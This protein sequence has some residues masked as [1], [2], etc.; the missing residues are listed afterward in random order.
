MAI[1]AAE[2]ILRPCHIVCGEKNQILITYV[3]VQVTEVFLFLLVF[4]D[5]RLE[6]KLLPLN[7]V[8]RNFSYAQ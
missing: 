4:S 7:I 1:S 3:T 2:Q 6:I 5:L 8:S